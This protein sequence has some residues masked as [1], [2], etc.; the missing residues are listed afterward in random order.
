M[1]VEVGTD[2]L[3]G[4]FEERELG[5]VKDRV[6]A[7]GV[8]GVPVRGLDPAARAAGA[9]RAVQG[10]SRV[11]AQRRSAKALAYFGVAPYPPLEPLVVPFDGRDVGCDGVELVGEAGCRAAV[12]RLVAFVELVE[13]GE[14]VNGGLDELA[15]DFVLGGGDIVVER[16]SRRVANSTSGNST[17]ECVIMIVLTV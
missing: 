3:G 1:V 6:R 5:P 17:F 10:N 4:V 14:T 8:T 7:S 12:E 9:E 16:V 13:V 11:E 15:G 2:P